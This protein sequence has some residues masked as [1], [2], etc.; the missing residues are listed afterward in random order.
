MKVEKESTTD[1]HERA[2]MGVIAS[3]TFYESNMSTQFICRGFLSPSCH[4][5]R[6]MTKDR[7]D[8]TL[9]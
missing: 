5:L 3:E 4:H 6:R 9:W 7:E 2:S 1:D 8:T